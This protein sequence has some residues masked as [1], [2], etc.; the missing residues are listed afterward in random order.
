MGITHSWTND[1]VSRAMDGLA[2]RHKALASNLANVDTPYYQR[3]EV[4]FENQLTR[5]LD[6]RRDAL[7]GDRLPMKQL[8]QG[9]FNGTQDPL[10]LEAVNIEMDIETGWQVRNDRNG[11]N[12]EQEM[13]SLA[14]N[15]Q[16]YTALTNLQGRSYRAT[17]K[18]L[19]S[20]GQV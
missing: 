18:L 5:A 11:V 6:T 15:T 16:R 12:I 13:A 3:R 17:H 14:K 20:L 1:L 10:G 19:D 2:L 4:S 7:D 8:Y 9:H